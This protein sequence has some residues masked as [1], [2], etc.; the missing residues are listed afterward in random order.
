[1]ALGVEARTSLGW[2]G[3]LRAVAG[4]I[5]LSAG[6][7][8]LSPPFDAPAL[9]AQL[10]EWRTSGRSF[11]WTAQ[12]IDQYVLP[13]ADL[14]ATLVTAGELAAGASLLLGLAS[15]LGAFAA[16]LMNLAYFLVSREDINLLMVG[17]HLAVLVTAGGRALGLD[18]AVKRRL[19]WWFLG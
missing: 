4:G 7:G 18:G 8:K 14:F 9:I 1:M 13:R 15:R 19:P 6:F 12:L 11:S 17:I 5:L 2:I 10:S 3:L 16:L